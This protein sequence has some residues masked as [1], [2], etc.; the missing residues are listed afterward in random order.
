M[1][2]QLSKIQEQYSSH[3]PA[4]HTLAVLVEKGDV[5]VSTM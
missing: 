4:L 1:T 2:N 5:Y 3:I